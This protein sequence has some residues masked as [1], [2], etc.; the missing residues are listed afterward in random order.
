[1]TWTPREKRVG[2]LKGVEKGE[3]KENGR[4]KDTER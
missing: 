1:V 3:W 2:M 4:L